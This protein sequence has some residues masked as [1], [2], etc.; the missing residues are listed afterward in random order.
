M[1]YF[2]HVVL[3]KTPGLVGDALGSATCV[4]ASMLALEA[5]D[6]QGPPNRLPSSPTAAPAAET[7]R[8]QRLEKSKKEHLTRYY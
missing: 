5:F 8:A 3:P 4:V 1:L 7:T 6:Q 2:L